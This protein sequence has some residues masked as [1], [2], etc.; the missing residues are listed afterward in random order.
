MFTL[1]FHPCS[2]ISISSI[3]Y[4]ISLTTNQQHKEINIPTNQK[5]NIIMA[6]SKLPKGL[7]IHPFKPIK[8]TRVV[9]NSN[10]SKFG[11]IFI[12]NSLNHYTYTLSLTKIVSHKIMIMIRSQKK[13]KLNKFKF[14]P[15]RMTKSI[16]NLNPKMTIQINQTKPKITQKKKNVT[17]RSNQK[18]HRLHFR[19]TTKLDLFQ[20]QKNYKKI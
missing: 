9:S 16:Q 10:M 15:I 20:S 5:N 13:R 7:K 3:M 2:H 12:P 18:T 11:H 4:T 6:C 19:S 1:C 17:R 8:P 14:N